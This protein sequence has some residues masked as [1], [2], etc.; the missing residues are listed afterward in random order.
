MDQLTCAL[1]SSIMPADGLRREW[2]EGDTVKK[3]IWDNQ[4]V[5]LETDDGGTTN[6]GRSRRKRARHFRMRQ[7]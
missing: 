2:D 5:L 6:G 1:R 4:D 3:F 7:D